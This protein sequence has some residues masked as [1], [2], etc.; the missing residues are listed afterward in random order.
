MKIYSILL[1]LCALFRLDFVYSQD[2]YETEIIDA[3]DYMNDMD[4]LAEEMEEID[5]YDLQEILENFALLPTS[6]KKAAIAEL[7]EDDPDTLKALME[8]LDAQEQ[9]EEVFVETVESLGSVLDFLQDSSEGAWE[10]ILENKEKLFD[11]IAKSGIMSDEDSDLFKNDSTAWEDE[12]K[13]LWEIFSEEHEE[14][15]NDDAFDQEVDS[16]HD[17]QDEHDEL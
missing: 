12:L 10:R 6:E 16:E 3:D 9:E 13:R 1:I 14:D 2:D 15:G 11:D 5:E 7:F 8:Q 4:P 17:G